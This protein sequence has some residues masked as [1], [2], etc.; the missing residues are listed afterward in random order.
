MVIG[1]RQFCDSCG[2]DRPHPHD[3]PR[4]GRCGSRIVT[5]GDVVHCSGCPR[6][7][8]MHGGVRVVLP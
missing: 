6:A 2:V 4:C 1:V 7:F 5:L 3:V 8:E